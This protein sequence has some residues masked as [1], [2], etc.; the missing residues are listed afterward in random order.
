[1]GSPD[2]SCLVRS[3]GGRQPGVC[4]WHDRDLNYEVCANS[5]WLV[6]EL[7]EIV[8]HSVGVRELENLLVLRKHTHT[9]THL[10]S[11]LLHI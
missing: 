2:S 5:R 10:V 8:G 9:H 3:T 1:M 7:H 4:D 11:E 6:S